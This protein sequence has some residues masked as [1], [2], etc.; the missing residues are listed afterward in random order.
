MALFGPPNIEK[1]KSKG[2]VKGLIKV[3]TTEKESDIRSKAAEALG[4]LQDAQAI[5]TLIAALKDIDKFVRFQA[6]A[7]LVK[8][9]SKNSAVSAVPV[10]IEAVEKGY[11]WVGS[12]AIESLGKIG[13]PRAIE[14]LLVALKKQSRRDSLRITEEAL[15]K[16]DPNWRKTEEG[17]SAVMK[18]VPLLKDKSFEVC[19]NVKKALIMIGESVTE[20][21]FTALLYDYSGPNYAEEILQEINPNWV[22]SETARHAIPMFIGALKDNDFHVREA[23]D[24]LLVRLGIAWRD[25]EMGNAVIP[26]LIAAL[27]DTD[28]HIRW[29][30]VKVLGEIASRNVMEPLIMELKDIDDSVR[31]QATKAL[32]NIDPNWRRSQ[33]IKSALPNFL[34]ALKDNNPRVR[35]DAAKGLGK[36]GDIS[37]VGPLVEALKDED[38]VVRWVT[39]DSLGAIGDPSVVEPLISLLKDNDKFVRLHAASALCNIGD[40]RAIEPFISSLK[41]EDNNVRKKLAEG[42]GNFGDTKAVEPLSA[43]LDDINS[44]VRK[45]AEEALKKITPHASEIIK[46]FKRIQVGMTMPEVLEI[47]GVPTSQTAGTSM[48]GPKGA[49]KNC[50]VWDKPEGKYQLLFEG[51]VLVQIYSKPS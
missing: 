28:F 35:V 44:G 9:D 39:A 7:A 51:D 10:F 27:K 13:D 20:P 4:E 8:I 45:E 40:P 47:L 41:D 2:D 3:L 32:E 14:P 18:L 24:K 48:S 29:T 16:I 17:K 15:N 1:L 42:L 23:A 50:V 12:R 31:D 33:E 38:F 21:L 36:I 22:N 26:I 25:S 6:A 37:S 30:V 43:L 5:R 19:T 11:D 46:E 34:E 49:P